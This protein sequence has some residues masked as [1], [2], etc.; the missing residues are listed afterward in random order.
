MGSGVNR[1][2][3]TRFTYFYVQKTDF[4]SHLVI[5]HVMTLTEMELQSSFEALVMILN[6]RIRT[7]VKI[8]PIF[9]R[10]VRKSRLLS[11]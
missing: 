3:V 2:C 4:L 1:V 11:P 9:V 8:V 5:I 7:A 6:A 10:F